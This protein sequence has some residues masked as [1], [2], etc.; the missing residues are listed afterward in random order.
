MIECAISVVLWAIV[1]V[2]VL[3]AFEAVIRAFGLSVPPPI[4]TLV[5]VL[6]VLLLVLLV[7]QCIA[8]GGGIAFDVPD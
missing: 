3:W 6:A 4:L 2:V 1:L 8:G 5:R 7:I